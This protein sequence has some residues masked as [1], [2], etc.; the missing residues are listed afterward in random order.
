MGRQRRATW[1]WVSRP[2]CL[3]AQIFY[4]SSPVWTTRIKTCA[5]TTKRKCPLGTRA[6]PGATSPATTGGGRWGVGG[7]SPRVSSQGGWQNPPGRIGASLPTPPHLG[8]GW[9]Q[10]RCCRIQRLSHVQS[11]L[12]SPCAPLLP[13]VLGCSGG[14]GGAGGS[15]LLKILRI[16][17]MMEPRQVGV[18][19]GL[20]SSQSCE[21]SKQF[22]SRFW[23][24][25]AIINQSIKQLID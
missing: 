2:A 20:S 11:G 5:R 10:L 16:R 17:E 7:V 6:P 23:E 22:T 12:L 18:F 1:G 25:A 14:T 15:A 9:T 4:S 13:L 24:N 8:S 21:K 19:G 3:R